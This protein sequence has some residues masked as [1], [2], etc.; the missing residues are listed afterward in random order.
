MNG[1]SFIDISPN[2]LRDLFS[3]I[4]LTRGRGEGFKEAEVGVLGHV[5]MGMGSSGDVR[6]VRNDLIF[7][8][9]DYVLPGQGKHRQEMV[10]ERDLSIKPP[11][12][13]SISSPPLPFP[14]TPFISPYRTL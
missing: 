10:H 9:H 14:L 11:F 1:S 6:K 12:S 8:E 13:A 5:V 4:E 3:G 7:S 2:R